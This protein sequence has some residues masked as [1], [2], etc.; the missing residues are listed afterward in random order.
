MSVVRRA[1][2]YARWLDSRAGAR[3]RDAL[4]AGA[5]VALSLPIGVS[6]GRLSRELGSIWADMHMTHVARMALA[7]LRTQGILQ[8]VDDLDIAGRKGSRTVFVLGSGSSINDLTEADWAVIGRHDSI[9]FNYWLIHS[10]MPTFYFIELGTADLAEDEYYAHLLSRRLPNLGDT[11]I[12]VESKCWLQHNGVASQLPQELRSHLFFYAPYY[13]RTSSIEVVA[14]VL[15]QSRWLWRHGSCDLR[16]MIHHRASLSAIVLFAFLAGYEEIVL[17]GV[18]L[19]NP[20][21][22]WETDSAVLGGLAGPPSSQAG[23]VHRTVDPDATAEEMAIPID[24]YLHLL[25]SS[26]L[27]PSGVALSVA[28]SASRLVSILPVY[29]GLSLGGKGVR[30]AM[31][32]ESIR[33]SSD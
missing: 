31:P 4:L 22:F 30:S 5:G 1:Y 17:V 18:D 12:I 29:G 16:A 8:S 19:N 2:R 20:R 15:R 9:G 26:L 32:Q 21:Y 10:F 24:E 14:W 3:A 28:S 23:Q 11:P 7:S 13:L 6:H 33:E 25:D 27:R